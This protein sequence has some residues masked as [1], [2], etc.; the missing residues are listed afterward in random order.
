MKANELRVA[1]IRG[2]TSPYFILV[3]ITLVG[4]ILRF[5]KLG[6]WGFWKDE[7]FTISTKD[8]GLHAGLL[9]G[10]LAT[11][12]I[13]WAVAVLGTS[14]WSARLVPA[15][16]GI[17]SIPILY[18]P[19]RM[20]F[21]SDPALL[22]SG[23]LAVSPWHIYWSQ[24]AR[25]YILLLLF[26]T[27]SLL[28]LAISL[29]KSRPWLASVALAFLFLA[30]RESLVALLL[31]PIALGYL[32][33]LRFGR[34]QG[35]A[36]LRN[37]SVYLLLILLGLIGALFAAPYV[38]YFSAWI[39]G[40]GR[41]NNSPGWIFA[42]TV[43]YVGVPTI[44]L[45]VYEAQSLLRKRIPWGYLLALW[46]LL[47]LA[48]IMTLSLFHY[49]A[50]RYIF[51]SLPAW[52]ILAGLAVSELGALAWPYRKLLSIGVATL[53]FAMLLG[54]DLYYYEY[55]NGNRENGRG[56]YQFVRERLQ[57]GDLVVASDSD[58]GDYYL[59]SQTYPMRLMDPARFE[60]YRRVWLV[61]DMDASDLYPQQLAWIK[62]HA[63]QVADFDVL[64]IVR[65]FKMR[66]YL[67]EVP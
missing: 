51:I 46:A 40:F 45:G 35:F 1:L 33:L 53:S 32:L 56:A 9:G 23:L 17:I 48:V 49:T 34:A 38:R 19:M 57:P 6:E 18:F 36:V 61:E 55:Q 5:Y 13:K 58:V 54:Q 27:L 63:Q 2:V 24:N 12:L 59:G 65:L 66:V 37:R 7:I 31:I 10:S 43:Y 11:S 60:R 16:I 25:F 39:A 29:E 21:G 67:Y 42:A 30:A 64:A 50:T 41:V 4:A 28:V 52:L 62:G 47:P 44:C 22:A 26:S 20:L 8:D 3:M 15:I 14:E